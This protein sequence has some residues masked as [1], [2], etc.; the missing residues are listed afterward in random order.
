MGTESNGAQAPGSKVSF[1][2]YHDARLLGADGKPT[3]GDIGLIR[4]LKDDTPAGVIDVSGDPDWW[5]VTVYPQG[6]SVPVAVC[7][8]C[9]NRA[10]AEDMVKTLLLRPPAPQA[11]PPPPA[12]ATEH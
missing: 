7:A 3:G 10:E 9:R 11:P 2:V 5:I 4:I 12:S 1:E 8:R 6:A